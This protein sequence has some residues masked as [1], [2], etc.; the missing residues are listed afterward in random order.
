MAQPAPPYTVSPELLARGEFRAACEARDFQ[1]IFRLMRKYDGASQ[2]RVSSPVPGLTQSRV[3]RVMSGESRIASLTLVERIADALRIPGAYFLLAPRPWETSS[4]PPVPAGS[5][6]STSASPI[7]RVGS[8]PTQA[9]PGEGGAAATSGAY[10]ARETRLAVT[11]DIAAD[12][13][14]HLTYEHELVNVGS[15]PITRLA[16][17]LWFKHTD[18]ILDIQ[19][20]PSPNHNVIIQRVHDIPG[21]SKFACQIFPALQPGESATIGYTC[22]KGR[23][24]DEL[25]WRQSIARPTDAFV[26]TVRQAGVRRLLGC[27][28]IEERADGLELS[29]LDGLSWR[30]DADR[31][32]IDLTRKH[33]TAGQAVTLRWDADHDLA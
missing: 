12:G 10:G 6:S 9:A 17:E 18:D 21:L 30:N 8:L 13:A 29:A 27:N 16:R 26:L 5:G 24:V 11:I 20:Q 4:P 28:A 1:V 7:T 2:D 23:F 19:A 25:Y 33:L 31:V 32:V 15:L 22:E 14:A 3:S